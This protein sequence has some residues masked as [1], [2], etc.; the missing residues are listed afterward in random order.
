MEVELLPQVCKTAVIPRSPAPESVA[1]EL[2]QTLSGAVE[3]DSP[4][5]SPFYMRTRCL[6][7]SANRRLES[8][9]SQI[10]V[11][12]GLSAIARSSLEKVTL[13]RQKC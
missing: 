9:N 4:G 7:L 5:S 3:Q 8:Q 10:Y 6:M 2:Q 12:L 13:P 1:S 11:S